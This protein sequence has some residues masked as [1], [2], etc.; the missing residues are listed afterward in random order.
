MLTTLDNDVKVLFTRLWTNKTLQSVINQV[1]PLN[2]YI[3]P[4]GYTGTDNRR[5]KGPTKLEWI[6][7]IVS[8]PGPKDLLS[9]P[10]TFPSHAST[11]RPEGIGAYGAD[12]DLS[13]FELRDLGSF[14]ANVPV[15]KWIDIALAVCRLVAI[16]EQDAAL[17][18]P[19]SQ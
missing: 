14:K 10:P 15:E 7:S 4:G 6:N 16:V 13:L 11:P 2:D 19:L 18:P 1:Y 3:F 17:D 12:D 8:G 5:H 9:P